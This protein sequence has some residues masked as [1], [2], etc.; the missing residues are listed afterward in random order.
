MLA[1]SA[2]CYLCDFTAG[3]HSTCACFQQAV[4]IYHQDAGGYGD[5]YQHRAG[6]VV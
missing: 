5:D 2:A 4:Y 6:H 1:F 3:S